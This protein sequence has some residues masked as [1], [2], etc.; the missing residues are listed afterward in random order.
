VHLTH[1]PHRRHCRH[2]HSN[3]ESFFFHLLL[4]LLLTCLHQPTLFVLNSSKCQ[5]III[6]SRCTRLFDDCSHEAQVDHT[7]LM[8]V[9]LLRHVNSNNARQTFWNWPLF[10]DLSRSILYRQNFN[11]TR[12]GLERFMN[13]GVLCVVIIM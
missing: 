5:S 11:A 2:H 4:M 10:V 7:H 1:S 3:R 6:P 8:L 12:A 13:I 9:R